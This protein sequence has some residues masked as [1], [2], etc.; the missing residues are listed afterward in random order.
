M[1]RTGKVAPEVGPQGYGQIPV[2]GE[3][4]VKA[5]NTAPNAFC[6]SFS[7]SA[8]DGAIGTQAGQCTAPAQVIDINDASIDP[9]T[10]EG[11]LVIPGDI[12]YVRHAP[13]NVLLPSC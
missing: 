1:T 2:L 10:E 7:L 3:V 9:D 11:D 6:Q 4:R 8:T 13:L 12:E 5:K